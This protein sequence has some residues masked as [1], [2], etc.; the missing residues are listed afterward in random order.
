M[1]RKTVPKRVVLHVPAGYTAICGDP[2]NCLLAAQ[3]REQGF[4]TPRVTAPLVT[5]RVPEGHSSGLPGGR[6]AIETPKD[7]AYFIG[8][9]DSLGETESCKMV[10]IA[11]AAT[12]VLD[13][14]ASTA[15][16]TPGLKNRD[17]EKARDNVLAKID[18]KRRAQIK[19]SKFTAALRK[20][21]TSRLR[22]GQPKLTAEEAC[23]RFGHLDETASQV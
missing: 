6:W 7:M 17:A 10:S 19:S 23:A 18:P 22:A 11:E 20:A 3:L 14:T 21:N 16:F 1:P 8:R 2:S 13:L 5:F 4:K 9:Y 12:F 15:K